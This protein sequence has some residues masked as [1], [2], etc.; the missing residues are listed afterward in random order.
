MVE[1]WLLV[2]GFAALIAVPTWVVY[3]HDMTN[4]ARAARGLPPLPWFSRGQPQRR[5]S[6]SPRPQLPPAKISGLTANPNARLS[7]GRGKIPTKPKSPWLGQ[8]TGGHN[9]DLARQRQLR[10]ELDRLTRDPAASTRLVDLAQARNRDKS[11]TWC[12]E[13]AI[14][15]LERDRR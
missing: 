4:R 2:M 11:R 9:P 1:A 12:L 6:A 5:P 7:K 14:H 3:R 10:A 13:K 8:R 15:D